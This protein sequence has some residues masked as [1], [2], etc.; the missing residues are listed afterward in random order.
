MW[1]HV[2]LHVC[3]CGKCAYMCAQGRAYIY[4]CM[5]VSVGKCSG[6]KKS[7][8]SGVGN[9]GMGLGAHTI[10]NSVVREGYIN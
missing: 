5:P 1:A 6:K 3:I 4:V 2:C 7:G 9:V 8:A 10:L